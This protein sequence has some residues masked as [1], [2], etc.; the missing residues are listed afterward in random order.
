MP[1]WYLLDNARGALERVDVIMETV[2]KYYTKQIFLLLQIFWHVLPICKCKDS[3][4]RVI[5]LTQV[6]NAWIKVDEHGRSGHECLLWFHCMYHDC[7]GVFH[8]L[9]VD[10]LFLYSGIFVIYL[11]DTPLYTHY[12]IC[13]VSS[14]G[15]VSYC[16]KLLFLL[17]QCSS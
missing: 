9:L 13:I 5:L 10:T 3:I 14:V 2:P 7:S 8:V 17:F 12:F 1:Q 4:L 6:L 15:V 11:N 16:M